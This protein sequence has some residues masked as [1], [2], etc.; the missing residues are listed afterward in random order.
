MVKSGNNPIP[1]NQWRKHWYPGPAHKGHIR[2]H[3]NQQIKAKIR[4]TH[5]RTKAIRMFPKPVRKLRPIVRC[6]T[7]K[8]NMKLRQGAGFSFQELKKVK[9]DP[10]YAASIGIAV[11]KRR[12]NRCQE[13]L[14]LNV[15]RLKK[16]LSVLVLFPSNRGDPYGKGERFSEVKDRRMVISQNRRQKGPLRFRPEPAMEKCR[17]LTEQ[18][19]HRHIFYFLRKVQRDQKLIGIRAKRQKKR[20][21]KAAKEK[22]K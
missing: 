7:K 8:Y 16:Y 12:K 11:D 2:M 6:P 13:S 22:D 3:F 1:R 10:R 14:D 4:R 17:K 20:E 9:L 15:A 5:R 21:D 18:E 19:K